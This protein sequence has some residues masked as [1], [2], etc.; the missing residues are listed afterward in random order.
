MSRRLIVSLAHSLDVEGSRPALCL[1][2]DTQ[3]NSLAVNSLT[4]MFEDK[5]KKWFSFLLPKPKVSRIS[6]VDFL[7]ANR[8]FVVVLMIYL[9]NTLVIEQ[10]PAAKT[11]SNGS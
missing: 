6:L 10:D 1:L 3:R 11:D 9:T 2:P 4:A 8:I 5:T 7:D